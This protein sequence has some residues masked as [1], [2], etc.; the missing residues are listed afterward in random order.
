MS[1]FKNKAVGV[2]GFVVAIALVSPVSAQADP[3]S[4][5]STAQANQQS[6]QTQVNQAKSTLQQ[7]QRKLAPTDQKADAADQASQS[8]SARVQR[9]ANSVVATRTSAAAQIQA[10]NDAYTQDKAD[11]DALAEV[12][13]WIAAGLALLFLLAFAW[14]HISVRDSEHHVSPVVTRLPK[15]PLSRWALG[16]FW[17]CSCSASPQA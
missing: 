4:D 16:G 3:Y 7:A 6:A 11:H 14:D 17:V 10:A 8:A 5:L 1:I 15:L 9:I 2:A 12:G 13:I